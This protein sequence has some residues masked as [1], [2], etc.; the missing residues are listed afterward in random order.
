MRE[1][2]KII[3]TSSGASYGNANKIRY[4]D[5]E[6]GY[7]TIGCHYV[8]N[9]GNAYKD[10][11]LNHNVKDGELEIGRPESMAGSHTKGQN[12]NSIGITLIGKDI[13]TSSQIDTLSK[14]LLSLCNKYNIDKNDI[15]DKNYFDKTSR[16]LP[17]EISK[18]LN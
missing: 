1:I 9:N 3:V 6:R 11:D 4:E 13:F 18:I 12:V 2:N 17:F 8:I 15:Y 7:R 14:L 5:I 10:D 16:R